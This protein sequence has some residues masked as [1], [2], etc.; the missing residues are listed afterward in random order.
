MELY[1]IHGRRHSPLDGRGAALYGGR[2]NPP[3]IQLVYAAVAYEGALLEQLV[4]HGAGEAPIDRIASRIA[5]PEQC[6]VRVFEAA[7]HPDW[8]NGITS[9]R[10]GRDWVASRESVGMQV[11]S[12]VAQPW[13]WNVILNPLHADFS[14]VRVV[15][16]V[17]VAW[18]RRLF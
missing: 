12:Y 2:W 15:D 14:R 5:L 10:I 3:G 8:H 11:P 13:G 18:D 4:H 1:R 16:T 17:R 9:R 6:E 7:D